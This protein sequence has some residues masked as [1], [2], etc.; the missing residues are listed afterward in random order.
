MEHAIHN[1]TPLHALNGQFLAGAC[2]RVYLHAQRM[3]AAYLF[4]ATTFY[5]GILSV[6][7]LLQT[8]KRR[9]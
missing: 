1:G 9:G 7:E 8:C 6:K 3:H 4:V 2:M 5:I